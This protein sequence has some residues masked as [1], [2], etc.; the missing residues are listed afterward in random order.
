MMGRQQTIIAL[1]IVLFFV[2]ISVHG[3]DS[4][5]NAS[6]EIRISLDTDSNTLVGTQTVTL[7]NTGENAIDELP[8]ALLAN[9][10]AEANP[11]VHPA[12]T[13][14]Q[15]VAGFDPT[16]TKITRIENEA[17]QDVSYRLE[18]AELPFQTYSL[19]NGF[20][21]VELDN[22]LPPGDSTTLA[23]GFETKFA[24]AMAA[25]NCLYKDTYVWRFGWNPVA[26]NTAAYSDTFELPAAD[27]HVELTIPEDYTA[28]GGADSQL[29][30]ESASGLK[31]IE[32]TNSHPVRSVPLVIGPEIE[33]VSTAWN[34]VN[35]E[36]VYLP[37]GESYARSALSY[38]EQILTYHSEHFGPF[39]GQRLVIAQNPT[40][41]FFGMAADGLVLIGSSMVDLQ[42]MPALGVYDRLNEYLL[43]HEIAHLWWGI[44][45]GTDFNSENWISE[46]FAEYLSITY[47]EDQHGGFDPNL[48]SHL[49]A[50]LVED[51]IDDTVGYMNLRQHLSELPYLA[52][53][54]A[55]FDE[56]IIQ[57]AKNSKYSNGRTVRTYNK[58]Y[59]VLRA[60][61][62]IV[63]SE[64]M[65]SI[66][67]KSRD[68]W[69]GKLLTVEDFEELTQEL[70]EAD[71]SEFFSGW[72]HGDAQFDIA[73]SGFETT[74]T[75]AGYSTILHL[76]GLDEIFPIVIEA[77]L[78]DESTVRMTFKPDCCTAIA[79]PF[80]TEASIVS[81]A[82]DPD[83]MLPDSNRF[84]NHWPRKILVSHPFQSDDAPQL[85]MP[86]DAYILDIT[87]SGISGSFRNDHAWSVIVLP[88]IDPEMDWETFDIF[89][90]N[91]L[92][93]VLGVFAANLGRDLG[94]SF[95]GTITA[96]DPLTGSGELDA[97]LSVLVLGFSH[98]NTGMV[99]Q[100]WYP[101]WQSVFTIGAIGELIAPIPYVSLA[102][103]RDD[104]LSL[105]MKT[106]VNLQLGVP[107]FGIDFFGTVEWDMTKR[108][109]LA[110]L[111]YIDFSAVV[112]ETLFSDLPNEFLFAQDALYT[113]D[114]LPMGHHQVFSRIE[115]VLPPLVRDSGYALLNLTRLDS[116]TPSLFVQGGR[117][118]ANCVSVCEPG[119][120]LEA[121][122]RLTF[123]LPV[124][125][126]T[127]MQFGIGY[128]HPLV[129]VDGE[130]RLF[131]DLGGGF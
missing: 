118:Q 61:E 27:Y 115:V 126:G 83:E 19:G 85:G 119:I 38:A 78:D 36:A 24:N 103:T 125:L 127:V 67:L 113:F 89:D 76:S 95:T 29:D 81:I 18:S 88:N 20:L 6:Y 93:D 22:P 33:S 25:D 47:F 35:I 130:G 40:A 3:Q 101:T 87:T 70:A 58:G 62:A 117:T 28:F 14:P 37:G 77:T 43:A 100:H 15:Y 30:L 110:H 121:G 7:T 8:F 80:E 86:L 112:S 98:P 84:N 9:W 56:P 114:N 92:L 128:A 48:L 45:I 107:G 60:L 4:I 53:L 32:L 23:I 13:D 64:S 111:F 1:A 123:T 105:A 42:N 51:L 49:Q 16:W 52:L 73:I 68:K 2:G 96:L 99:G 106:R 120:R 82:I 75:D 79:P 59:L 44:G 69:M 90:Y 31:A 26:V 104:T 109:R 97:S 94:I 39:A 5:P 50:G 34:G 63:G 131:V 66:L 10:G 17:G 54:Q 71:L 108:F 129:G 91:P 122:A 46:G 124:F 65:T 72:L 116:I 11:Y 102:I 21:I 55:S 12:L 57:P 74:Q 41:G